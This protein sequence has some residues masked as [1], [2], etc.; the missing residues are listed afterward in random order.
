MKISLNWL[1]SFIDISESPEKIADLL[2]R[3]GLEVESLEAYEQ[4]PGNL[5]G[6]VVGQVVACEKHPD[7]DKLSLTKV[8]VGGD[9]VLPIV[10]GAPNVATGQKVLVA[11]PGSTI[12]PT[13]GE[14]F[15]IKKAK[16]RGAVSEGMIC[17]E[18]EIGLG[19]SHAGIL[20]LNS[21]A[22]PGTPA[23]QYFNFEQDHILEIGLTPN[24]ADAASHL[25]VARDLKALLERELKFPSTDQFQVDNN[26]FKIEVVVENTVACP[27]YS[28]ITLTGITVSESPDWLK[29]RLKSI[30]VA[31]I[32]NVVDI[33]NY[34]LHELGQ[35]LH[36]FDGDKIKGQKV[37]VK[38]LPENTTFTTLD[39]KER[40]LK[41]KDLMICDAEGG[42]CIAGVFGGI[43]S[44]ITFETKKIFLESAC[45]SADYIR[46]TS[47]QHGLKTDASFRFERGTDPD[48][49]VYALKRAA[50]L[51]KELAGGKISSK[52][53]DLYADPVKPFEVKVL[54]KNID[55]LIGASLER[56]QIKNI[57]HNLEI[58]ITDESDFGFTCIVPP[59]RVDVQREADIIEEILRIYGYDR[60]TISPHLK[61]DFLA[62]FP[63]L[64]VEKIQYE[65]SGMLSS[66]GF[67]E[68]LTN[69]LTKPGYAENTASLE[70]KESIEILNKL[71]E[72]L[73]VLRQTLLFS[74]LEVIAYNI[75]RRQK[76]LK[77]FEFGKHY[78]KRGYEYLEEVHLAIFMTGEME[79]ESWRQKSANVEFHD[80][81][82]IIQKILFRFKIDDYSSD[83]VESD[84]F[85]YGLRISIDKEPVII[86][87]KVEK[88]VAKLAE[89]KQEVLYADVNW[90][91]LLSKKNRI[92]QVEE[93]SRFPEVR[94]DLSLVINK[95]IT[96]DQIR[97]AAGLAESD[98]I[99][100]VN[101]FDVYEGESIGIQNKAYALSFIL[102]DKE[103]TLTDKI[104][105]KTM[106]RL[107]NTFEQKLGAKIRK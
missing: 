99:R 51:I 52:I 53:I 29:N 86:L 78:L 32:N 30:G 8:D 97:N 26:E 44:G 1:K 56:Y 2:T 94:R 83:L 40:K 17:A 22:R 68:I 58:K 60:I 100:E 20:I 88:Q 16:I 76:D 47:L 77:L 62:E 89:V 46:K 15:T 12:H 9:Q 96:F 74:G 55:R 65:T 13:D 90:E 54:Y 66:N 11:T 93:I 34:V 4:V 95:K 49:T 82:S 7:A 85:T 39:G 14:P 61:T 24:R 98:L 33:T 105:D 103:R 50:L 5:E 41:E 75:N 91:K 43:D 64:D 106:Q 102:Q 87:G 73:G 36:A 27:R 42:M 31:P 69:S 35:P 38:T 19:N 25:G 92:V 28:G 67:F 101:I 48:I 6:V 81:Y 10:C 3:S 107:M 23:F 45:F 72:D 63:E 59:Y 70:A 18:D 104:I 37:V 80:L 57:L 84:L 71:S 79:K 21:D